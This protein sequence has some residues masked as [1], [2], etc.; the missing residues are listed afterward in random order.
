MTGTEAAAAAIDWA[1]EHLGWT[2]VIHCITPDNT[3]SQKVAHRLGSRLLGPVTM[4]PPYESVTVERWGQDREA[5][6]SRRRK[7]PLYSLTSR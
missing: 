5:W 7:E 6:R 1:F 2:E 3:A 4:P